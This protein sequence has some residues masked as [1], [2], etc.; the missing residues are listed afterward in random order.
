MD[1]KL[2]Q[3][4]IEVAAFMGMTPAYSGKEITGW[5]GLD[6]RMAILGQ[7]KPNEDWNELKQVIDE[8]FKY[9]IAYPDQVLPVR[10]MKIVVD[11]LPAWEQVVKFCTWL[12]KQNTISKTTK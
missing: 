3:E 2:Q 8:I 6:G 9:A 1:S 4:I 5:F 11:I 10:S 7:Y 12:I